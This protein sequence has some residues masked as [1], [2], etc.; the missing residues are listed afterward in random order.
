MMP[1]SSRG[2]IALK[3]ALDA[4]LL[5]AALLISYVESF[6]PAIPVPG[7]KLGLANMCVLLCAYLV[8]LP[9]AAMV[10]LC[11]IVVSSLLFGGVPSLWFSLLGGA[12]SFL[13]LTVCKLCFSKYLSAVGISVICAAF[14][15]FGQILAAAVMLGSS[16]VFGYLP[17]LLISAAIC[18]T[19]TGFV[20]QRVIIG[21]AKSAEK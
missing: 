2:N 3:V 12:M 13:A 7:V 14:H 5:G 16:A 8:S 4:S 11:R 19:I 17:L 15:N 6:I 10:S 1:T 9:D 21:V 18:G 20:S